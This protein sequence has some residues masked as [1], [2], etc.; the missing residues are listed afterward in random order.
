[1]A[2]RESTL[3]NMVIT[4]VIITAVAGGSLGL[5]YQ[6]TKTPIEMSAEERQQAAIQLVVPEFDNDPAEEMYEL[7]SDEGFILK[8]FPAKKDGELV[9]AA[10]ETRSHMGFSGDIIIMV[11]L[12]PDGTVIDY[13]V[14]DHRETPGLGTKMDDWFKP[15]D[16]DGSQEG[17]LLDPLF[18]ISAG[19]EGGDSR[20]VIGKNPGDTDML[21]EQDGG[22]IDAI[23]AAT[24]TSRAFLHAIEVAYRT[25]LDRDDAAS[26][27]TDSGDWE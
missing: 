18:G 13:Q 10:I 1:M 3:P 26:G 15:S 21:V 8:V 12:T 19:D 4:L 20:S 9:G 5:I 25:Y 6:L 14:L 27:A 24:I 7:T 2:K 23:T 17:R 11:G 22:A 16:K